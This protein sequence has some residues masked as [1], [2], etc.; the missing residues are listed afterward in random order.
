VKRPDSNNLDYPVCEGSNQRVPIVRWINPYDGL[1]YS[2]PESFCSECGARMSSRRDGMRRKHTRLP[3][4]GEVV[5]V[6][7]IRT[8]RK[9]IYALRETS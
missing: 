9:H 7:V 3:R 1:Q 4:E 6:T 8:E 2:G 5:V